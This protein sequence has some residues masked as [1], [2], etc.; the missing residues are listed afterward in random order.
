MRVF[1]KVDN[2]KADNN[3]PVIAAASGVAYEL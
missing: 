2:M 1:M 3:S